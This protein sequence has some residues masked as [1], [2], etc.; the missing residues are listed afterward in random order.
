MGQPYAHCSEGLEYSILKI[1]PDLDCSLLS[2][3]ALAFAVR[4]VTSQIHGARP[5]ASKAVV[6]II[7]DTSLDSVDTAVDAARSNRKCPVRNPETPPRSCG[8][9]WVGLPSLLF[10]CSVGH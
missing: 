9:G 2:G 7:M 8:N 6:M 5:G 10:S 3:N 1:S 4:Y